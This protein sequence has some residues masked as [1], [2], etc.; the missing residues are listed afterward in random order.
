MTQ[1]GPK[2]NHL[3]EANLDIE[4]RSDV[5]LCTEV[6]KGK[7]NFCVL[8]NDLLPQACPICTAIIIRRINNMP[9]DSKPI[10]SSGKDVRDNRTQ[11]SFPMVEEETA[12]EKKSLP[13]K[14]YELIV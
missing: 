7:Q 2:P 4:S 11:L 9:Q 1:D 6:L 3:V 10:I 8:T 14:Q 13:V 5:T 12:K